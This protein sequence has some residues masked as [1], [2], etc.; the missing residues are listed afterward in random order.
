MKLAVLFSGGK[1]SCYALHKASKEHEIVCLLSIFSQNPESYMFHTPNINLT[2]LQAE[3]MEL[4]LLIK[5]TKGEKELEL[6]DLKILIQTAIEKY[7]IKGVVTGALA[8]VY[9]AKRVQKI[10]QELD[11]WCFNP[12]WQMDQVELLNE[13]IENK[14]EAIIVGVFGYP[15]DDSYLG[16]TIDRDMINK[17][18]SLNKKYQ[19]NPA[20][21]GGE[22]ETFVTDGPMFKK[23]ITIKES[24]IEYEKNA[25]ILLIKEAEI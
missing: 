1:D 19:I 12:L 7:K 21:E 3:S 14:F 22:L 17:L 13:L 8:S 24:E 16:K 6:K 4:P 11:L 2:K 20:G 15:L 23:K 18:V 5:T 9:Q 10:C 25:G